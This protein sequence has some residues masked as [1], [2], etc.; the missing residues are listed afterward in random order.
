M[1]KWGCAILMALAVAAGAP[2]AWAT[3]GEVAFSDSCGDNHAHVQYNDTYQEVPATPGSPRFDIKGVR[4]SSVAGGVAVSIT[5]CEA[6]GASDG[7]NGWRGLYPM[8]SDACQ[9]A[10]VVA[11]PAA[12]AQPREAR[13]IETCWDGPEKSPI[14]PFGSDTSYE[15]FDVTL[16]A[17]A[18]KV[19]GDT[20]TITVLRAGL[21]GAAAAALAPGAV[22]RSP[23]GYAAETYWAGGAGGD[24][25]GN[26]ESFVSPGLDW[27][28]A[29]DNTPFVVR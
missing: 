11:E 21:T 3:D 13:F 17:D 9:L 7:L 15:L 14:A 8:I 23:L 12:P 24:S 5:T 20:M 29:S 19:S 28:F 26:T 6:P 27:A 25:N 16:P 18:I 10:I 4:V 22:W 2:A 1:G